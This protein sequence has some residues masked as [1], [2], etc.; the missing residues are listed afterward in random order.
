MDDQDVGALLHGWR[1]QRAYSVRDLA[2]VMAIHHTLL[3]RIEKG[4]RR[5]SSRSAERAEAALNTDGALVEAV[6]ARR[7]ASD[8]AMVVNQLPPCEPLVDRCELL[9]T[10]RTAFTQPAG[11]ARTWSPTVV[12]TGPGGIGKTA[13]AS[14][15]AY[16]LQDDFEGVLWADLRGWDEVTGRRDTALLLRWWCAATANL[17]SG[18]LPTGLDDLSDLWRSIMVQRRFVIGIDNAQSGQIPPL[19]PASAGSVVLVT[20]RE[21]VPEVPGQVRWVPVPPLASEDAITLVARRSGEEP[22]RV[23]RLAPRGG[24]FPLALRALGDY[25]AAH[26]GDEELISQMSMDAAPP[27]AVRQSAK[28]SYQ[29]LTEEQARAWRLCA[30]LPEVSPESAAATLAVDEREAC[31][32]LDAVADRTLLTKRGRRWLFHELHRKYALEVS[33]R[34][35]SRAERDAAA[36]RAFIFMLHGWAHASVILAPD[37]SIGPPLDPPPPSVDPPSF[38]SYNSALEWAESCWEYLSVSVHRSIE[39]GWIRVAWQLVACSFSYIILVKDYD[40]AYELAGAAGAATERAGEIEGQ[41]WMA[42]IMGCIDTD[43]GDL[44]AAIQHLTRSLELRRRRGDSRDIGWSA[45]ALA[46]AHL[47]HADPSPALELLNEAV[48]ALDSIGATSAV[49]S[50]LSLRGTVYLAAYELDRADRDLTRAVEQLPVGGDP[51][52][53]CYAY[54]RLAVVRL[55]QQRLAEAEELARHADEYGREHSAYHSEVDALD[56]LGQILAEK[57]DAAGSRK[58]WI[59]A[60]QLA[61]YRSSPEANRIQKQLDELDPLS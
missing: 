32:A 3:S 50:T 25:V 6:V 19:I 24:G 28:V 23:A 15:A 47:Q 26:T 52:L 59:R 34:V 60:V 40:R 54:T 9:E 58:A 4:Q 8:A 2:K 14:A 39:R 29:E 36:E 18:D 22:D 21:R 44:D 38:D 27:D 5:L 43:R 7:P 56:V 1:L 49:G 11:S 41:A 16:Q 45:Q 55:R 53:H 30:I 37:R 57:G 51:L 31:S 48:D 35:D 20:S 13:V 10:I 46:R 17:A 42:H 33:Q 12:L 61:D